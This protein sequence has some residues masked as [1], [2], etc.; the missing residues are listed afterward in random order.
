MAND[1]T[2]EPG[3]LL[4]PM[5]LGFFT[6][7]REA[8]P[9][10]D[11]KACALL[12]ADGLMA[13]V[14]L[15]FLDRIYK[16][17]DDPNALIAWPTG[18]IIVALLALVFFGAWHAFA[19]LNLPVPPMPETPAFYPNIAALAPAD[20]QRL[21]LGLDEPAALGA[22]LHYNHA[23]SRLSVAKFRRLDRSFACVRATFELWVMLLV[24]IAFGGG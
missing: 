5:R 4:G 9:L 16:M 13:S 2:N 24:L 20:Y 6:P 11:R 8:P 1:A 21:V 3:R 23:L 14:L 19:A 15:P 17:I 7:V 18:I 12:A 10:A 22:I